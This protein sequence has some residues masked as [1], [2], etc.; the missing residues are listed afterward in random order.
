MYEYRYA[1]DIVPTYLVAEVATSNLDLGD[2]RRIIGEHHPQR[3]FNTLLP[4]I[5]PWHPE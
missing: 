1:A 2:Q 4:L 3:N 5:Q